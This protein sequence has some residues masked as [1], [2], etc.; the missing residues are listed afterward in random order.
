MKI[1]DFFFRFAIGGIFLSFGIN[2]FFVF[3]PSP[4]MLPQAA[5]FIG[6]LMETGYLWQILG[7]TEIIGGILILSGRWTALGLLILA[8]I[9][10]NIVSY[11]LFLQSGIGFPPFAMSFFLIVS[12]SFLAFA[13]KE[14]YS[15]LFLGL[16]RKTEAKK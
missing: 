1:L 10:A 9:V 11:L 15:S 5:R 8:P 2:K 12:G 4:P 6:S 16:E 14:F 3:I 7:V 13:R